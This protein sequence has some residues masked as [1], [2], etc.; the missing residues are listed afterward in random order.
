MNKFEAVK[1]MQDYIDNNI[2]DVITMK[3]LSIVSFYSPWY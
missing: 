1:R 2:N 3:D